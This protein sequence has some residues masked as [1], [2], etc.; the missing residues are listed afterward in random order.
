MNRKYCMSQ[1]LQFI[2][3]GINLSMIET[4]NLFTTPHHFTYSGVKQKTQK[5]WVL[6]TI[7]TFYPTIP[8]R[9]HQ[10]PPPDPALP[11]AVLLPCVPKAAPLAPFAF[12]TSDLPSLNNRHS[13]PTP[14]RRAGSI[15]YCKLYKFLRWIGG[16]NCPLMRYRK[17]RGER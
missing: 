8:Y 16:T 17:T 11:P 5:R 3:R 15:E 14:T 1:P 6:S 10:Y 12:S 7:T 4:D 2:A 13:S 9:L